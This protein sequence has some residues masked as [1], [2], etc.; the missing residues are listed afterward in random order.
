MNKRNIINENLSELIIKI[1]ITNDLIENPIDL[2]NIVNESIKLES[3]HEEI[4]ILKEILKVIKNMPTTDNKEKPL[5]KYLEEILTKEENKEIIRIN[6]LNNKIE[7][8]IMIPKAYYE[9]IE[10]NNY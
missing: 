7:N 6:N 5:I 3:F 8:T 10:K 2:K 1:K 9:L 4:C